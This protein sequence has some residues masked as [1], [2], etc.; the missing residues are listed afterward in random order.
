ML[1]ITCVTNTTEFKDRFY[2]NLTWKMKSGR[3]GEGLKSKILQ[4]SEMTEGVMYKRSCK[5]NVLLPKKL[6][7]RFHKENTSL[8][9]LGILWIY[10][11]AQKTVPRYV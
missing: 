7:I 8:G 11:T 6:Q 1:T 3:V 5:G 4:W 10:K 2:T 9:V